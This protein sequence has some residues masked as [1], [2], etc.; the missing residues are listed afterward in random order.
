MADTKLNG[1]ELAIKAYLD[2]KAKQDPLFAKTYAK[3]NKSIQECCRYI[4]GEAKKN[5]F[6]TGGSRVAALPDAEVYNLAVHYYDEDDIKVESD[7]KAK[8]VHSAEPEESQETQPEAKER[9]RKGKKIASV[10]LSLF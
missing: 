6:S 10:E 7:A 5:M 9:N 2:A 3:Q 1:F 8:V 4:I